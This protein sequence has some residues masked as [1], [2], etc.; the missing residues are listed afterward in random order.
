MSGD[1]A[2]QP[3]PHLVIP[4]SDDDLAARL[5]GWSQ[6]LVLKYPSAAQAAYRALV[7]EGREFVTTAEGRAWRSR[8]EASDEL[9]RLRPL[10]EAATL[11]VL[12]A[13]EDTALPGQYIDLLAQAL[14]RVDLE[15]VVAGLTAMSAPR[16]GAGV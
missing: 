15:D 4:A 3:E 12:D 13:S 8:L 2:T 6:R 14:S 7:A 9:R 1:G 16:G 10:W 11:S 5:V